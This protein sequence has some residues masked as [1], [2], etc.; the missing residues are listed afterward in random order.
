MENI[1]L[2]AVFNRKNKLNQNGEALIHIRANYK[3]KSI[4]FSTEISI[5]PVFW[6]D[7][8]KEI[9]SNHAHYITF[10]V[11]INKLKKELQDLSI[12]LVNKYNSISLE[13]L[14]EYFENKNKDISFVEFM[15]TEINNSKFEYSTLQIYNVVLKELK[16]YK[17]NIL[18][19]DLSYTFLENYNN[20]L[21]DKNNS[22]NTIA[23]KLSVI[24]KFIHLAIKKDIL[25]YSKNPF[26]KFKVEKKQTQR[27]FFD[28]ESFY[29]IICFELPENHEL[30]NIFDVLL[31]SFYT[32][33]RISD[34]KDLK[35]T[36]IRTNLEYGYYVSR[37][38]I[39]TKLEVKI[40]VISL[41]KAIGIETPK[42]NTPTYIIEKYIKKSPENVYFFNTKIRYK[43]LYQLFD[44]IGV[45]KNGFHSARHT[46]AMYL[47]NEKQLDILTVSSLLGHTNVKTTQIYSRMTFDGLNKRLAIV[48]NKNEKTENKKAM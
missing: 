7:K 30:R 15:K 37:E 42:E 44:L 13:L 28:K 18:F 2:S 31:F 35:K 19:S 3:G 17:K 40:P 6:N 38:M 48:Y 34:L 32:A 39:K 43:E 8:K 5:K 47:L 16:E 10:N 46:F 22:I 27:E 4:Y 36:D 20:Y 14:K 9:K 23:K 1:N 11:Q 21:I 45:K 41:Y 29:K 24:K 12:L 25:E 26:L 33:L